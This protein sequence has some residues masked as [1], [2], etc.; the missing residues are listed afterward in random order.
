[1]AR[2][3]SLSSDFQA[4][5]ASSGEPT[6]EAE[7]MV[8]LYFDWPETRADNTQYKTH[9]HTLRPINIKIA[10]DVPKRFIRDEIENTNE[11]GEKID[12]TYVLSLQ[13][14]IYVSRQIHATISKTFEE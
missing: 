6:K 8:T 14:M 10:I 2:L 5:H 1:M 3:P 9:A 4:Q 7:E 11:K 12:K 13:G